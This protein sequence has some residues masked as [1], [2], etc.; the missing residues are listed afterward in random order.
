MAVGKGE[1]FK[2]DKV[3]GWRRR[4]RK[5]EGNEWVWLGRGGVY[6]LTL[7][8]SLFISFSFYLVLSCFT[9]FSLM[10]TEH[11]PSKL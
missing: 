5:I 8:L 11:L 6:F 7:C 3:V 4:W 10:F 2:T 1:E 9:R